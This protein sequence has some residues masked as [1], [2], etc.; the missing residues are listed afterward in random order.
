MKLKDY[1]TKLQEI[2]KRY[3]NAEMIYASDDEGNRFSRISYEPCYG[4]FNN[5]KFENDGNMFKVNAV[6]VN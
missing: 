3:P 4:Y 1:I 5:G 2:E 6:C